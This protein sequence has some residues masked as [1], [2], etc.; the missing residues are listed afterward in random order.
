MGLKMM[1]AEMAGE[2][3][4]R[5]ASSLCVA[6]MLPAAIKAHVGPPTSAQH[7]FRFSGGWCGKRRHL[8]H[9]FVRRARIVSELGVPPAPV[10]LFVTER[11]KT[12]ICGNRPPRLS[13]DKSMILRHICTVALTA[14][15]RGGRKV[16]RLGLRAPGVDLRPYP[17][18]ARSLHSQSAAHYRLAAEPPHAGAGTL[19]FDKQFPTGADFQYN[20]PY[21]HSMLKRP[22]KHSFFCI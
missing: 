11:E 5:P 20:F 9:Q 1:H 7:G 2:G 16:L 18:D 6:Q 17:S 15:G 13:G 4:E 21:F 8:N 22:F 14:D 3:A 12:S 19:S 10:R